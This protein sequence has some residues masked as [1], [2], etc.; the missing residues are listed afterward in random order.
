[1]YGLHHPKPRCMPVY[2]FNTPVAAV[3]DK[4]KG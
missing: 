3:G 1:M 2:P 4:R